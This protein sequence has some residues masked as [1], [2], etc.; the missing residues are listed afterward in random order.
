MGCFSCKTPARPRPAAPRRLGSAPPTGHVFLA[1]RKR[2]IRLHNRQTPSL[3]S[4]CLFLLHHPFSLDIFLPLYLS[5]PPLSPPPLPFLFVD[6]ASERIPLCICL[7]FHHE[8]QG[9]RGHGGRWW[10]GGSIVLHRGATSNE[11]RH[12]S[13]DYTTLFFSFSAVKAAEQCENNQRKPA[14]CSS[15]TPP[16]HTLVYAAC[17]QHALLL[18]PCVEDALIVCQWG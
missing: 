9:E 11:K 16:P 3:F 4:F 14:V 18:F 6:G 7:C 1:C 17:K 13:V 10:G 15:R 5:L 2:E 8:R 12:V